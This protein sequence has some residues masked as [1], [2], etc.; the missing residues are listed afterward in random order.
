MGSACEGVFQLDAVGGGEPILG[1]K[2]YKTT[3]SVLHMKVGF[4]KMTVSQG[5]LFIFSSLGCTG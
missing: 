5:L 4:L 3:I 2:S 1:F